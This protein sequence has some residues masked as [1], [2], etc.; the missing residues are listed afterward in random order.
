MY[1]LKTN[2]GK[3]NPVQMVL[4]NYCPSGQVYIHLGYMSLCCSL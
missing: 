2:G 4:S 3:N 1:H